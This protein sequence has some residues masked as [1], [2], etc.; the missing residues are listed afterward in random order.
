MSCMV[1]LCSRVVSGVC[2]VEPS[3]STLKEMV[4]TLSVY[5]PEKEVSLLTG[6]FDVKLR[7]DTLE[8]LEEWRKVLVSHTLVVRAWATCCWQ[9]LM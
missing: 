1:E 3:K 5:V 8:E 6:L 7:K 2:L 9:V 4:D